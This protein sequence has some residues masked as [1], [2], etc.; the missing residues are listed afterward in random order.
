MPALHRGRPQM[1][2]PGIPSASL[3]SELAM[4]LDRLLVLALAVLSAAAAPLGARAQETQPSALRRALVARYPEHE[5]V[6]QSCESDGR[7]LAATDRLCLFDVRTRLVR[8]VRR[9]ALGGAVQAAMRG[10]DVHF[11]AADF[12]GASTRF[13]GR[14]WRWDLLGDAYLGLGNVPE[15]EP[16][17]VVETSFGALYRLR[18]GWFLSEGGSAR[19]VS[20]PDELGTSVGVLVADGRTFAVSSPDISPLVVHSVELE[21]DHVRLRPH[22]TLRGQH[23]FAEGGTVV[24]MQGGR[25]PRLQVL[26]LPATDAVEVEVPASLR[27]LRRASRIDANRL[28]LVGSRRARAVLDVGAGTLDTA[29][30]PVDT[31]ATPLL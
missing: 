14:V 1:L 25:S 21:G 24:A 19:R 26:R 7:P 16:P 11:G 12:G 22:A 13:A 20:V 31:S 8:V 4:H 30:A 29:A 6:P 27:S 3:S 18:S 15:D 28:L 2:E 10:T 23:V 9:V 5:I 17:S